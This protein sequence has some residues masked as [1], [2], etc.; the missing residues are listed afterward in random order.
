[1][2]GIGYVETSLKVI[3]ATF[4]IDGIYKCV[5]TLAIVKKMHYLFSELEKCMIYGLDRTW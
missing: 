5:G 3:I 4:L 1:M 2:R